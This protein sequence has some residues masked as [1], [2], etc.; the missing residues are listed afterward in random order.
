MP[1]VLN[2][3][4]SDLERSLP[5]RQVVLL[6]SAAKVAAAQNL[7]LYLVGGCVRDLLLGVAAS[8]F[9]LVVEGDAV[10][11]ARELAAEFGGKVT[12]HVRFGT[13][14]WFL[15]GPE[16]HVLDFI[17]TRSEVYGHPAALPTVKPGSLTDDLLRRDFSINTL[18]L[19]L[20]GKHWGELHDE[21][22]SL[23]DLKKGLVRVLHPGS[24]QDDP[25]R[26]FRAVRYEQR[27]GFQI[28]PETLSLMPQAYSL[29]DLLS[30]QRIRHELDLVLEEQ[31]TA[32]MLGRLAELGLVQKVHPALTWNEPIRAR[33]ING[34]DPLQKHSFK[35]HPSTEAKSLLGWHF[36]L[37]DVAPMEL[38]SLERRL[39]FR[40]NLFESL[41]AAS[42][43]SADLPSLTR[44]KPSE[45]V[46]RLDDLPLTAIQAVF[47]AIPDGKARQGLSSYLETWRRIKPKTNGHDLI[48][49]GLLQG[50][51]YQQ[52]LQRL[53]E[54]WLDGEVKT[55][56]EEMKLLAILVKEESHP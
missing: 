37:M 24:F 7:P 52:I 1:H 42:A 53:R 32:A 36:W 6:R 54:A 10:T 12:C 44:L 23:E 56:S 2:Y 29:I 18:A 19:R 38:Q 25:T 55:E 17:S 46:R 20:D 9:D 15:A 21:L 11:L 50:P 14:Q 5:P 31:K 43:L 48:K 22:G 35:P 40:A 34:R 41:L 8:D 49:L 13:A 33:F 16:H 39:H 3:Q 4:R 26:L 45:W 28:V 47:L 51:R 27:Y 30:P